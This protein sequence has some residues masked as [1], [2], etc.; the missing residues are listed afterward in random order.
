[1]T[2]AEQIIGSIGQVIAWQDATGQIRVLGE[3]WNARATRPVQTGDT[4][5]VVGRDGLTLIVDT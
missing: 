1:M 3:V 5:R 2:G 4:V